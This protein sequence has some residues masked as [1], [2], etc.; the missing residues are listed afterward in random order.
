MSKLLLLAL[1]L[2]AIQAATSSIAFADNSLDP[3]QQC[4]QQKLLDVVNPIDDPEQRWDAFNETVVHT[5]AACEKRALKQNVNTFN[6]LSVYQCD[7]LGYPSQEEEAVKTQDPAGYTSGVSIRVVSFCRE[8]Y[9][10]AGLPL[11]STCVSGC[12]NSTSGS[13]S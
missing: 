8:L 10:L 9:G 2:V 7:I 3:Q 6:I 1:T 11:N 4:Y 12:F 5:L 13:Q